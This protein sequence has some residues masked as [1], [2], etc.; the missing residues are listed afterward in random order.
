MQVWLGSVYVDER[1][2]YDGDRDFCPREDVRNE[3]CEIGVSRAARE[4]APSC[5]SGWATHGIVDCVNN[6]VHDVFYEIMLVS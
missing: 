3:L 1:S 6:T 4:V 5:G 2:E